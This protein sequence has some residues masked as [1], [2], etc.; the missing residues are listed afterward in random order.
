[1]PV[2]DS[3]HNIHLTMN[4]QRLREFYEVPPFHS[5][6]VVERNQNGGQFDSTKP[7]VQWQLWEYLWLLRSGN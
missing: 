3:C 2:K 5:Q 1:M 6:I 7:T 4:Q